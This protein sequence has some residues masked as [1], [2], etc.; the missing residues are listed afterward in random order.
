MLFGDLPLSEW[1][2]FSPGTMGSQPWASFELAK[3]L[4][5]SDELTGAATALQTVLEM[6]GLESRHYLQGTSFP[7]RTWCRS[8]S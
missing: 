6:P 1:T 4:I 8:A 5:D 2:S 3:Q 7:A